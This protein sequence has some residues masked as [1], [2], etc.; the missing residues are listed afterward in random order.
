M[1][2]DGITVKTHRKTVVVMCDHAWRRV[3]GAPLRQAELSAGA[4]QADVYTAG[5][6]GAH[7]RERV[8]CDG[9]R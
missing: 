3:V 7:V 6:G 8:I 9:E 5:V 1:N 2:A 4:S